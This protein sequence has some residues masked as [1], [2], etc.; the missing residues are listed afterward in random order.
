MR[1]QQ[2]YAG[3]VVNRVVEYLQEEIGERIKTAAPG[4]AFFELDPDAKPEQTIM[5]AGQRLLQDPGNGYRIVAAMPV[6]VFVTTNWTRLLEQ[7]LEAQTPKKRPKTV[8]FPWNSGGDWPEWIYNEEPT[9][10]EPLVYHLFGRLDDPD[11][12]VLTEDDYFEWLTAWVANLND[13]TKVPDLLKKR[14]IGRSLLFLGYQLDDWEFRAVFQAINSIPKSQELL[15]K[16]KHV[17][18]QLSPG[19]QQVQPEAAQDYL[20]SYFGNRQVS[21]YWADT[22]KFLGEYRERMRMQT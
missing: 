22:Q 12:L 15:R 11:S 3:G 7:A 13:K 8:Y 14:L 21:I 2:K 18:V 4:D 20:E 6:P 5:S 17:G 19:C 1:V 9:V 10:T 16:N